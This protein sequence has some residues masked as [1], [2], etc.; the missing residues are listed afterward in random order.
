M[1]AATI[2]LGLALGMEAE[3]GDGSDVIGSD[4]KTSN[5]LALC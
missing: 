2:F 4:G 1:R 5:L 3:G